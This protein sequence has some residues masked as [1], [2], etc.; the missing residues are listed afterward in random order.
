MKSSEIVTNTK[1][2]LT[3]VKLEKAGRVEYPVVRDWNPDKP[4]GERWSSAKYFY[5]FED[6]AEYYLGKIK[7]IKETHEADKIFTDNFV[8]TFFS[9]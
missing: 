4:E 1:A 9:K 2:N 8:N 6:A 3:L 5:T 7:E